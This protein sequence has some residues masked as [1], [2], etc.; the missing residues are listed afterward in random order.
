MFRLS[1][2]GNEAENLLYKWYNLMYLFIFKHKHIYKVSF[3]L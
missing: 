2:N 3:K 1:E